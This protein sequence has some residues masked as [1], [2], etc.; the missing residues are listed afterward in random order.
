MSK[1]ELSKLQ[2]F[3]KLNS[4]RECPVCKGELEKGYI[5]AQEGIYWDTKRHTILTHTWVDRSAETI[6]SR[7]SWTTPS[8]PA[9]RCKECKIVVFDYG[10]EK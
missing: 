3:S 8:A 10:K 7:W 1:K 2:E 4:L 5:H 6:I 9:L